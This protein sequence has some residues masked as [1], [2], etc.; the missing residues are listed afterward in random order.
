ML[1]LKAQGTTE[2]V[3]VLQENGMAGVEVMLETG[4]EDTKAVVMMEEVGV[5]TETG[6]ETGNETGTETGTGVIVATAIVETEIEIVVTETET[7]IGETETEIGEIE[8]EIETVIVIAETATEIETEIAIAIE[9]AEENGAVRK[10]VNAA[11]T[12]DGIETAGVIVAVT[13]AVIAVTEAVPEA[14]HDQD[15]S[16][17]V[18]LAVKG[19]SPA[20]GS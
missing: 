14:A 11:L 15:T 1:D 4:V 10:V 7:E 8:T 6:T 12:E 18:A 3:A 20:A 13:R 2:V 5:E 16:I 17:L 19:C 9:V